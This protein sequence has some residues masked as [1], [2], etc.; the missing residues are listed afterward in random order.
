MIAI[1]A[2]QA[3]QAEFEFQVGPHA[4]VQP[5]AVTLRDFDF[6]QPALDLTTATTADG[7]ESSLEIYDYPARYEDTSMG[8]GLAKLRLEEL[9]ARSEL[10]NGAS[11]CRRLVTGHTLVKKNG[12]VGIKG[13]KIEVTASG[14]VIIKS[15][16][17]SENQFPEPSH[18]GYRVY[19]SRPTTRPTRW[20][21]ERS[22]ARSLE[23]PCRH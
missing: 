16:K 3:N 13:A 21:K 15:S 20:A 19:P 9:R 11:N 18:T 17:I 4:A 22:R 10:V 1:A 14:D 5:G 8:K 2:L 6:T 7:A 12:D 23:R